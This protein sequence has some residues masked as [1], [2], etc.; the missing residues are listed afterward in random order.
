[1][2]HKADYSTTIIYKITCNDPNIT[3]KYVGHTTDIVRRR[4]QHKNNACNVK[5]PN[6]NLKL[7]KFIRENG[8]WDNWKMEII[9][10]Y[11]CNNLNEARQKEQEHYNELKASLNSIEPFKLKPTKTDDISDV[12]R[13][14]YYCRECNFKCY[15]LSK[16]NNHILTKNHVNRSNV[17]YKKQQQNTVEIT[18]TKLECA[19]CDYICCKKSD[20]VKHEMTRK[21][22]NRTNRTQNVTESKFICEHCNREYKARNSLWYHERKCKVDVNIK[23]PIE[24]IKPVKLTSLDIIN[25]LLLDNMELKN[26]I[27]EQSKSNTDTINKAIEWNKDIINKFIGI[28]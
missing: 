26:L 3:D 15:K 9:A 20:M 11:N 28:P 13:N 22:Q 4:Q 17:I 19:A 6:Y 7:Y 21:H 10:H 1:M 24:P 18:G 16:W 2:N 12:V 25:K 27:I 5:Y 14:N 8:G 23:A